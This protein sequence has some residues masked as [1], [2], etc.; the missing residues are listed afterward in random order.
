VASWNRRKKFGPS[1]R[2]AWFKLD[3]S[4]SGAIKGILRP[5]SMF[6]FLGYIVKPI[7]KNLHCHQRPQGVSRDTFSEFFEPY[8]CISTY[9]LW[10]IEFKD[11][12]I[13]SAS[14]DFF[15]GGW[16]VGGNNILFVQ[17]STIFYKKKV[18]K[19]TI[20]AGQRGQGH[21]LTLHCPA[22]AHESM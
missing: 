18:R 15:P 12:S 16:L 13:H 14:A 2:R 11:K 19:N 3:Y 8:F 6:F 10:K 4:Y 9:F 22:D 7:S 20:W 17:K 5:S 1:G 21:P